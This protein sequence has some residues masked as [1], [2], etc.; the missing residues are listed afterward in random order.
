M[1]SNRFPGKCHSCGKSVPMFKG[2]LERIGRKYVVWCEPCYNKSD[3]SGDEDR[4]C[5]DR[6]YEDACAEKCG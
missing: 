1:Q 2:I 3:K 4:I 5:G 6:A